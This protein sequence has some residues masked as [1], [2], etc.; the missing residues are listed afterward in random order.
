MNN[1]QITMNY[2]TSINPDHILLARDQV[3]YLHCIL[4]T[5]QNEPLQDSPLFPLSWLSMET[6]HNCFLTI[7]TSKAIFRLSVTSTT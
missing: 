7:Q 6:N 5:I 1:S 3:L 4:Q 2:K